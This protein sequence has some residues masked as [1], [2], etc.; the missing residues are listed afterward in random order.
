[1]NQRALP[2]LISSVIVLFNLD[3]H[4]IRSL[5]FTTT[6]FVFELSQ[7]KKQSVSARPVSK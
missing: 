4:L 7:E 2:S 3:W 6:V 5:I 1:M